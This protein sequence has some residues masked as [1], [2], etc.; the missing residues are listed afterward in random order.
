MLNRLQ[1]KR[2]LRNVGK[3]SHK[4]L[5]KKAS[6]LG[7]D[8]KQGVSDNQLRKQIKKAGEKQIDAH[9]TKVI[10]RMDEEHKEK[11][12]NAKYDVNNQGVKILKKDYKD[13]L[14]LQNKFNNKKER[15]L[16][17]YIKKREKEGNPL[18]DIEL[19]FLK[20]ESVRH[21]NSSENIT[22]NL[23]FRKEDLINSITEGVNI[24]FYKKTIEDEI[25]NFR[26]NN[27]IQNRSRKLNKFL[28]NWVN[29]GDLTENR[30]KEIQ[31]LYKNMNIINK[32]QFNKDLEKKMTMVESVVRNPRSGYDVYNAL[33]EIALV[34]DDRDFIVN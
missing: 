1:I 5:R 17:S 7:L 3:V 27:V 4:T 9:M 20:G 21:L 26:I 29:S 8:V 34:Q 33:K 15:I 10:R 16:N 23:N 24:D 19:K 2:I 12:F 30:V 31:D 11:V 22:L 28:N 18:S 25:K 6:E 32:S 13:I 14:D